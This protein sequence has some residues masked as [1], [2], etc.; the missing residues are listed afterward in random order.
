MFKGGYTY[1]MSNKHNTALYV[2]VTSD[3]VNR[4]YKHKEHIFHNSFTDKYNIE[5][6]V[7]YETFE[8][9]EEAIARE[10]QIKKWNRQKKEALINTMNPEW[11]DLY[12][13]VLQTLL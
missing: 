12:G 6:L 5:F 11:K 13:H 3:L 9:I 2:G 4:V 8:S 7:Y 10:K 1:I